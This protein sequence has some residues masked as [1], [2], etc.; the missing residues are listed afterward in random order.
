MG[1]PKGSKNK[2]K[3]LAVNG[4][5]PPMPVADVA[6][7]MAIAK[8]ADTVLSITRVT[9][10]PF[11]NAVRARREVL[12]AKLAQDKDSAQPRLKAPLDPSEI[13]DTTR[14]EGKTV[15][16]WAKTVEKRELDA[17]GKILDLTD[18]PGWVIWAIRKWKERGSPTK[19]A[20]ALAEAKSKNEKATKLERFASL[21]KNKADQIRKF[22]PAKAK[23]L[24]GQFDKK[25]EQVVQLRS[26]ANA[27]LKKMEE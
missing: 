5:R 10:T 9:D 4:A 20:I 2:P 12:R 11:Q 22:E 25:M 19:D 17:N 21:D 15:G 7:S 6:E 24:M 16:T 8:A 3:N 1:R 18:I 27:I 14:I 13:K 26:E 23:K